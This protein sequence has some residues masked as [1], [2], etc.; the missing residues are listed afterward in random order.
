ML[1]ESATEFLEPLIRLV[2]PK[3]IIA[4]GKEAHRG[5][6]IALNLEACGSIQE[7]LPHSPMRTP[8]GRLIFTVYH[9][10]CRPK[11]RSLDAQESDWSHIAGYL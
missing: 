1:R 3:I 11:D 9:C 7:A 4:M 8:D 6:C 10:A 2:D 5:T